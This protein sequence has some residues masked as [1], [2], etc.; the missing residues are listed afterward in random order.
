MKSDSI[1]GCWN[2]T[3]SKKQN[4]YGKIRKM[5]RQFMVHR[6]AW[7]LW[8]GPIPQKM[9]IC[10]KCDNRSCFNPK[11]LFVGTLEENNHDMYKKGRYVWVYGEMNG[12]HKLTNEQVRY[13]KKSNFGMRKL[14]RI[15][16]VAH[17]TIS[18]IKRG[19]RWKTI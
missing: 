18:Y 4:G 15:M 3:G 6:L 8:N 17:S 7:E 16:G 1:T 14:G 10:H 2:W 5:Y 9:C 12:Q 11:H 13:I 19:L